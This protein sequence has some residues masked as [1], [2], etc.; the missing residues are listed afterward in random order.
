MNMPKYPCLD[1]VDRD[2]A[3]DTH[4]AMEKRRDEL[5]KIIKNAT[6][7]LDTLRARMGAHQFN[8]IGGMGAIAMNEARNKRS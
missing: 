4:F 5:M 3:I 8:C 6:E 1:G 2:E 7:E